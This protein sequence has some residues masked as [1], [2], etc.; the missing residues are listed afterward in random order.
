[1]NS[2]R[3]IDLFGVVLDGET[4][5]ARAKRL[6]IH[7]S[8]MSLAS[9]YVSR[10]DALNR[11]RLSMDEKLSVTDIRYLWYSGHGFEDGDLALG[12]EQRPERVTLADILSLWRAATAKKMGHTT[13]KTHTDH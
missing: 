6:H 3:S 10:A 8:G 4:L 2:S 9:G 5:V 13:R 1:M 12:T 11:I 7:I